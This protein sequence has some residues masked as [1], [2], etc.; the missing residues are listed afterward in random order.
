MKTKLKQEILRQ[1][2]GKQLPEAYA[3]ELKKKKKGCSNIRKKR[4]KDRSHLKKDPAMNKL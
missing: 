1:R 2:S 4:F 3:I